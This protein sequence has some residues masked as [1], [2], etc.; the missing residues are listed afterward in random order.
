MVMVSINISAFFFNQF[1]VQNVLRL[2]WLCRGSVMALAL[3]LQWREKKICTK[4]DSI[5]FFD[6][7]RKERFT[8]QFTFSF[9]IF[10]FDIF[11]IGYEPTEPTKVMQ[12]IQNRTNN[13][14]ETRQSLI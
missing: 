5:F 11:K 6:S 1:V 8:N 4:N 2:C 9:A 3:L 14:K 12:F 7:M 13:N 10:N